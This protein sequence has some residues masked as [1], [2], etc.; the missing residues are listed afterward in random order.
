MSTTL[1]GDG[2]YRA[3]LRAAVRLHYRDVRVVGLGNIPSG[4]A[5]WVTLHRNGAVD[6]MVYKTVRPPLTFLV[7]SQ[8]LRSAFGRLF[9]TGIPVTRARDLRGDGA[10]RGSVLAANDAALARCADLLS[11]GGELAIFPEGTSDLGPRH[12][13]FKPGAARVAAAAIERG[14]PL[15]LV[16]AAIF[17]S[18]PERFRSDVTVVIGAPLRIERLN[19]SAAERERAV[20]AIVERELEALGVNVESADDLARLEALA[21]LATGETAGRRWWGA[22][23]RLER[24]PV[25]PPVE[26]DWDT[27]SRAISGGR[28]ASDY[29]HL[30]RSRRGPLW[31]VLW[32]LVQAPLVAAGAL[33]NLPVLVGAW[34]AGRRLADARNTIALWRVLAGLPLFALWAATVV[35]ASVAVGRPL[36]ALLWAVLTALALRLWPELVARRVRLRNAGA[37]ADLQSALDRLERWAALE[38]AASDDM[39]A[40]ADARRSPVGGRVA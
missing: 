1:P 13:P 3:I 9:F 19:A 25:P 37:P 12:L 5:L 26:R 2:W 40:S 11:A 8:L 4:P 39:P 31:S 30:A 21:A 7:S 34:L 20:M 29:G 24:C 16:P 22:Q 6:G 33:V 23:K 14:T 35:I 38:I 28:L 15:C 36:L 27:V 18:A 17:Y 10:A 32:M